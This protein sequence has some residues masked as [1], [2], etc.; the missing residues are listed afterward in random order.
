MSHLALQRVVVRM[1][2]DPRLV[3]QIYRDPESALSD[4]RLSPEQRR[5]LVAGDRRAWGA[6]PLR[7]GRSLHGLLREYPAAGA[8]AIRAAGSVGVLERFFSS[9]TFHRCIQ[10]GGSLAMAFGAWLPGLVRDGR[11]RDRRVA[12]L[13]RLEEALVRVR[14]RASLAAEDSEIALSE[15][16]ALARLAAGTTAVYGHVIASLVATGMDP[17]SAALEPRVRLA[18][19]P[20]LG[21]GMEVGLAEGRADD[22]AAPISV[23]LLPEGL[24]SILAAAERGASRADLE[25]VARA[26]GADPGEEAEVVDGLLVEGLLARR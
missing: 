22:R 8:L 12:E 4:E 19:V 3:E 25:R 11:A 26:A 10:L 2:Y 13:A 23:E 7:R 17:A 6:D 16:V 24:A 1:L 5:W 9:R 14:R 15:H 21:V 20:T 18:A